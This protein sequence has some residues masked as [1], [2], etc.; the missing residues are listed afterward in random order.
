MTRC[1]SYAK[2]CASCILSVYK[3]KGENRNTCNYWITK[4][5][6]IQA[7]GLKI[8]LIVKIKTHTK[9]KKADLVWRKGDPKS[10][11]APN[12]GLRA[13]PLFSTFS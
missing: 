7:A 10:T 1:W 11:A 5:S 13:F 9:M 12:T 3:R 2:E 8:C 6:E 4:G